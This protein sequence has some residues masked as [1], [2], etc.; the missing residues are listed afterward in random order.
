MVDVTD[1][2]LQFSDGLVGLRGLLLHDIR[3]VRNCL[4]LLADLLHHELL[5]LF[6]LLDCLS[7]VFEDLGF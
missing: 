7:L 2:S 4:L 6:V 1:L 3:D 5:K